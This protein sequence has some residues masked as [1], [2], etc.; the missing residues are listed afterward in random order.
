MITA[1]VGMAM[2]ASG[3]SAPGPDPGGATATSP[4]PGKSISNAGETASWE[5]L[6]AAEITPESTVLRLG[7]TRIECASGI[8]GTVLEPEIQ[9][10][11]EQIV[12]R[13]SVETPEP[14]D[15]SC[16]GNNMVP[17]TVHLQ[18]PVGQRQLFDAACL[19]AETL[20]TAFCVDG[21]VRWR[22]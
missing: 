4:E 21:G 18:S 12:I 17:I 3:C 22:P 10:D 1:V 2:A 16:P 13:T 7:V 6:N 19:D 20:A 14:G 15:Y 8:T 9:C 11:G 5:L